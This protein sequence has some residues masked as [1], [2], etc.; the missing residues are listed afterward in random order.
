M[1][2]RKKQRT[3]T[4]KQAAEMVAAGAETAPVAMSIDDIPPLMKAVLEIVENMFEL[5]H[6]DDG[7]VHLDAVGLLK[8]D[9]GTF[10]F[11]IE[12]GGTFKAIAQRVWQSPDELLERSAE[13][14]FKCDFTQTSD[15]TEFQQQF[16][17]L[18]AGFSEHFIHALMAFTTFSA[19]T[20]LNEYSWKHTQEYFVDLRG[21]AA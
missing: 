14:A 2:P 4:G 3:S 20:M 9:D 5:R 6:A 16:C 15:V 7:T 1:P 11:P 8:P 19:S 10:P 13:L 18:E 21:M 17:K 12:Q